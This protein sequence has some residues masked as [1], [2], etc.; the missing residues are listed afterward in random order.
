[1]DFLTLPQ[2][3][4]STMY[5]VPD[6]Q[7]D[8]EWANVHNT[9]LLDDVFSLLDSDEKN[10]FFGAIVTI[11]YEENNGV[12]KSIEFDEYRIDLKKVKHV[13]DGQQRLTSFS[14]LSKAIY[15]LI[16]ER[17]EGVPCNQMFFEAQTRK[18]QNIFLSNRSKGHYFAPNLIL[19]GNTGYCFRAKILGLEPA[20]FEPKY[21]GAKKVIDAYNLFK[22]EIRTKLKG[23]THGDS[24]Q[25]EFFYEKLVDALLEKGTLVEICCDKS[26]NAF[27]VF[28]SLNGKGL[29]LT[30][31][32]RI[33]NIFMSMSSS[34]KRDRIWKDFVNEVGSKYLTSFFVSYF[35]CNKK[36]RISKNSLPNKFKEA[37]EENEFN[38]F[39]NFLNHVK[40]NGAIYGRLRAHSTGKVN[41]DRLLKRVEMLNAEQIYVMLFTAVAKYGWDLISRQA[42]FIKY[43]QS[44]ISLVVRMQVCQRNV[45]KLDAY[46]SEWIGDMEEFELNE[47]TKKIDREIKRIVP[48]ED[49]KQNFARFAPTDNKV[50]MYYLVEIEKYL[51]KMNGNRE[52]VDTDDLSLEHIIPQDY[53]ISDWY[54]DVAIPEDVEES[55]AS[56]VVESIGNKT[57]MRGDDN[58]S[59]KNS[60]YAKKLQVYKE[61]KSGQ[62]EGSP[63][64]TFVL[65][66]Q[67]IKDYPDSFLHNQVFERAEKLAEIAVKIW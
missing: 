50:S 12:N 13:V 36:K 28:D 37:Y 59:A 16:K 18:L 53:S 58:S 46:F 63:Y 27:Q 62:T 14:I 30:A 10:H 11:P 51:R 6:Y 26:S 64:G 21:R 31:A 9:T 5:A 17:F 2:I 34:K 45:N 42:D 15:D 40:E 22:K 39:D 4:A 49:F 41:I 52:E 57:L 24:S 1:M 67:L 3:F 66:E 61:G 20:E 23:Y 35:F 19:N 33:K 65:V 60:N 44:L 38:N 56:D 7:R 43:C 8:Y 54:G 25:D 48:D 29:D 55:F 32:D 47:I